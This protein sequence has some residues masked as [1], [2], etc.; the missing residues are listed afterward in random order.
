MK[1]AKNVIYLLHYIVG[2]FFCN[3]VECKFVWNWLE[4]CINFY[5]DIRGSNL[6][7][8]CLRSLR[9]MVK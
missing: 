9:T 3:Y 7:A 2:M 1:Q 5:F 8:I 4:N 6:I